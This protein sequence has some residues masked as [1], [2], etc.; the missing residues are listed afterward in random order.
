MGLKKRSMHIFIF[1]LHFMITEESF[2]RV[3]LSQS[4]FASPPSPRGTFGKVGRHFLSVT[5]WVENVTS[6][7]ASVPD[8]FDIKTSFIEDNF[9]KDWGWGWFQDNLSTLHLLC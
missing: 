2:N 7:S 4:N 6:S 1:T 5:T 8:L 9:S 3:I